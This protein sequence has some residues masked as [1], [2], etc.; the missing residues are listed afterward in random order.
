MTKKIILD[1]D[2]G[3]DDAMA[4]LFAEAHPDIEL[5]ALTTVFGNATIDN[6]TRN[7]LYLKDRFKMKAVI[8]KG[9]SQ[10]L[11]RAPVGPTEIV[12]GR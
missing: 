2:P 8:A 11:V 9:A 7:A 10:P 5:L 12:H 6:G 4:I 1:T 3:I